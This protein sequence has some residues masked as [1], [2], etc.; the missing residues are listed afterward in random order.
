MSAAQGRRF[1]LDKKQWIIVLC[2]LGLMALALS[3]LMV[4]I[5][6]NEEYLNERR[7][8]AI[9]RVKRNIDDKQA[10]TFQ[11]IQALSDEYARGGENNPVLAAYLDFRFK[12]GERPGFVGATWKKAGSPGSKSLNP[13]PPVYV[14]QASHSKGNVCFLV[15]RQTSLDTVGFKMQ[16]QAHDFF[17]PLLPG[18]GF[19]EFV[20]VVG[21][22][23]IYETFPSGLGSSSFD[24]LVQITPKMSGANTKTLS[25]GGTHYQAYIQPFAIGDE[26][27]NSLILGMIQADKYKAEK[28]QLPFQKLLWVITLAIMVIILLPWLKLFNL[29]IKDRLTIW[30]GAASFMV[31]MLLVSTIF[32]GFS[33]LALRYR[34]QSFGDG[35]ENLANSIEKETGVFFSQMKQRLNAYDDI[36][37]ANPDLQKNICML[38][39]N[40]GG[41]AWGTDYNK[42]GGGAK[43]L[44]GPLAS[45]INRPYDASIFQLF[46]LRENDGEEAFNWSS[47]SMNA[48]HGNFSKRAYFKDI[49]NDPSRDYACDQVVSWTTATFRTLVS[50]KSKVDGLVACIS[51]DLKPLMHTKLPYGYGFAVVDNDGEV[52][53]HSTP[54]H[55]LNENF[56]EETSDP[57]LV[58][59]IINS[60]TNRH[61]LTKYKGTERNLFIRP[62][63]LN[64]FKYSIIVF[65]DQELE[66][67]KETGAFSFTLVMQFLFFLVA[68]GQLLLVVVIS[69]R[70]SK[71][72]NISIETDWIWPRPSLKKVYVF[73]GIFQL[74]LFLVLIVFYNFSNFLC[75][76]FLLL[77]ATSC[78]TLF[79]NVLYRRFYLLHGQT[80]FAKYKN[81]NI[82]AILIFLFIVNFFAIWQLSSDTPQLFIFIA[83]QLCALMIGWLVYR[84]FKP[85]GN[86]IQGGEPKGNNFIK[87]YAKM[88]ITRL[89]I[90]SGLP[91]FCFYQYAYNYQQSLIVHHSHIDYFQLTN[92]LH[93]KGPQFTNLSRSG[94]YFDHYLVDLLITGFDYTFA[95]KRSDSTINSLLSRFRVY[96]TEN[97]NALDAYS[98]TS[99]KQGS[100]GFL[101]P[102]GSF[103]RG[104]PFITL[105]RSSQGKPAALVS[106]QNVVFRFPRIFQWPLSIEVLLYWVAFLAVV[107]FLYR[108]IIRVVRHI[109]GLNIPGDTSNPGILKEIIKG[110]GTNG[111]IYI[112]GLPGS[113]KRKFVYSILCNEGPLF[114]NMGNGM[115]VQ[116]FPTGCRY[117]V[118][119]Q[120]ECV[121][122]NRKNCLD[123][124]SL[125]EKVMKHSLGGTSVF[126][127]STISLERLVS[128]I[129]NVLQDSSLSEV[130]SIQEGYRVILG[131]FTEQILPLQEYLN[132]NDNAAQAKGGGWEGG[133]ETPNN[134]ATDRKR[135]SWMDEEFRAS[136]VLEKLRLPLEKKL[137]AADV[138]AIPDASPGLLKKFASWFDE[139]K[140]AQYE[141]VTWSLQLAAGSYYH[142]IWES[143]CP[144]ERYLVYDLAEEGL[145]NPTNKYHLSMLIQKGIIIRKEE[146]GQP[147][148]MND[149]FRTYVL[150]SVSRSEAL[151][152][153][154]EVKSTGSWS[155]LGRP[156]TLIALGILAILLI[157]QKQ[158]YA[159][160]FGFLTAIG[161][162]IPTLN[163]IFS[164]IRSSPSGTN[165]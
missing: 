147:E 12:P 128:L 86:E 48:P 131:Y 103:K 1:R 18:S 85:V 134:G 77:G 5:P 7:F 33:I 71:L 154:Q 28:V 161:A 54:V 56:A 68:F 88:A 44:P 60:K 92:P 35:M 58:R 111:K 30:D 94:V 76:V 78:I 46:W 114:I 144:E 102:L 32:M 136:M 43:A 75:F 50:K 122:Q 165:K 132:A 110:I 159:S 2:L 143:L 19:D 104:E 70:K 37:S 118:L 39:S 82:L 119:G 140:E 101:P 163:A 139:R 4:Y 107:I 11:L 83:F 148:L 42:A 72:N 126:I 73:S 125:L 153:Q 133:T 64:G 129:P 61:L 59:N 162:A 105:L 21:K 34:P 79:I 151:Q 65:Y 157:S 36:V 98:E 8:K 81:R 120:F 121:V 130:Q 52:L 150:S 112:T 49:I 66:I 93:P 17:S 63:N 47:D 20:V 96:Q 146:N 53:Y 45:I 127:L 40:N 84:Y 41:P 27:G 115:A 69:S 164:V 109:F 26:R 55:N 74:L 22:E 16:Y 99:M 38:G 14:H 87:S 138:K 3:Y 117:L 31:A 80:R 149:S 152:I 106:S 141:G 13:G 113:G 9:Q 123:G 24:T 160:V 95:F 15:E 124:L 6:A 51:F 137:I 23:V 91:V 67:I 10:N 155:D 25:L 90:T 145:V 100:I 156:L 142:H 29:G 116:S 62:V 57:D 89:L 97:S 135:G 158:A 108:V